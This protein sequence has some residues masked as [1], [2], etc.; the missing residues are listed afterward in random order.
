MREA[1]RLSLN[2]LLTAFNPHGRIFFTH[3]GLKGNY[4]VIFESGG[5]N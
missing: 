3:I 4:Q 1:S 2:W 5:F